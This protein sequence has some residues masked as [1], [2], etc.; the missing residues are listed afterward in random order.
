MR[1]SR[2]RPIV[3]PYSASKVDPIT[4][5]KKKFE[6]KKS[7]ARI[8]SAYSTKSDGKS[9]SQAKGIDTNITTNSIG[10]IRRALRS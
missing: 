4:F 3:S 1:I 8:L 6:P 7:D 2:I 9:L 5:P 10:R